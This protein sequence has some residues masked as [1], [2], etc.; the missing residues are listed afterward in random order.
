[1]SQPLAF[2]QFVQA[3]RATVATFPDPRKGKNKH[4]ALVDAALGAV[5]VFFTQRPAFLAS[6]R[7]LTARKG[8]SNAHTLFGLHEI[9]SDTQIRALLD[10]VSPELRVPLFPHGLATWEQTQQLAAVRAGQHRLLG[11]LDGTPYFSSQQI[12]CPNCSTQPHSKGTTTSAHRLLTPVMVAPG[13]DTGIPLPPEFIGPQDGQDKQES[14]NAAAKRWLRQ[15]APYYRAYDIPLLGAELYSNHPMGE[16]LV[17]EQGP[18]IL[19]CK[20]DS[21]PTLYAQVADRELGKDLPHVMHRHHTAQGLV[22]YRYRYAPHLP[23]RATAAA[24]A[25]NWCELPITNE[26]GTC[27][28]QTA[29]ITQEKLTKTPVVSI[30]TAGRP[31][32]TVEN[33]NHNTLKTKG[34]PLEHNCGHGQQH[35][36]S[37]LATFNILAVLLHPLLDR[38]DAKYRLVRRT[39]VSR[40]TF[41]DDLCALTRYICFAS[42]THLLDFMLHGLEVAL[43][44]NSS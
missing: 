35:L 1:M 44:P 36:A 23:L 21:P 14:E 17:E 24:I 38:L 5:A 20:P 25:V 22:S 28:S 9:P 4:S 31:R 3:F 39:L 18:F 34:Y 37:L 43:P 10:P 29:F 6:Q 16:V 11:G 30:V 19:G 26:Q 40:K 32:W 15:Y 2:E 7:D 13:Q 12:S 8:Q 41:F 33:E 27:L 42:W